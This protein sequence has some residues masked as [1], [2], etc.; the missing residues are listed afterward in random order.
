MDPNAMFHHL[1]Q[2][3]FLYYNTPFSL[4]DS[5]LQAE[6]TSLLDADHV[7]WRE[8]WLEPIPSY[9]SSDRTLEQTVHELGLSTEVAEFARKGLVPRA[10]PRLYSHQDEALV[11]YSKGRNVVLTAGTGS[12]KTEAMFLP[13]IAA[14]VSESATWNAGA[15]NLAS[16]WWSSAKDEWHPMRAGESGR[17]AAL[18][19]LVL[20]PMNALVEDQLVRLRR[21]LDS[22]DARSW[23]DAH[24]HGHRFFFGRYTGPTPV[25]G[26]PVKDAK[27]Y[28]TQELR[29][30]LRRAEATHAQAATMP[31]DAHYYVP[32][33][34]GAEMRSRWDML[35]H[36]PDIMITNYS[37]LNIMLMRQREEALFDQTR[38]WIEGGGTFHLVVDELHMYRGTQG[39]EVAYLIRKLLD[40]L[41]LS[42]RTDQLRILTSSASLEG[43]GSAFLEGFFSVP[44]TTFAAPVR[45]EVDT[46]EAEP[47][48]LTDFLDHFRRLDSEEESAA[49]ILQETKGGQRLLAAFLTS[50]ET[51]SGRGVGLQAQ[52][53]ASLRQTLFPGAP[54][55]QQIEAL[56]GLLRAVTGKRP[57]DSAGVVQPRIRQHLFFKNI[58]G[59]WACSDPSCVHSER[60][61]AVGKLFAR[62]RF[63]CDCGA[64]VLELL[65]CQNCGQVFLGGYST[66]LAGASDRWAM[67]PEQPDLGGV[68]EVIDSRK[69][70]DRYIVYWPSDENPKVTPN[71]WQRGNGRFSFQFK[72]S[73]LDPA[74]GELAWDGYEGS[75]WSFHV[76]QRTGEAEDLAKIPAAPTQCPSCGDDWERQFGRG[77]VRLGLLDSG[78]LKSPIR[79]MRTGF[80]KYAQVLTDAMLGAWDEERANIPRSA[81]EKAVIFSDSRQDAARLS[82]GIELNHYR[83]AVR[84]VI[85][86]A[87]Q[88]PGAAEL[89]G[90]DAAVKG[91]RGAEN[92]RGYGAIGRH[93]RESL[94]L[95]QEYATGMLDF[96][97]RESDKLVAQRL[98]ETIVKGARTF[99]A[100]V[101]HTED[102]LLARGI[103]PGGPTYWMQ[104]YFTG[105]KASRR[106]RPWTDLFLWEN[107]PPRPRPAADIGHPEAHE[108]MADIVNGVREQL[109]STMFSGMGRDLES[110]GLGVVSFDGCTELA[111][112]DDDSRES[113][114]VQAIQAT[115]RILGTRRWV[116]V[117][118]YRKPFV[119]PDGEPPAWLRDTWKRMA[120]A[121]G[122][123][124]D[125]IR[126]GVE[127]RMS[128]Q[129]MGY[130]LQASKL[131]LI[132]PSEEAWVCKKCRRRHLHRSA[133]VCSA[134]LTTLP[135]DPVSLSEVPVED[136]YART[137]TEGVVRRLHAEELT[138]QT[139]R[140]ESQARQARFQSIFLNDEIGLVD[141]I[142]ILSVTTTMEAGVDIGGLR[143]VVM[144]NMPPMRFNYQQRVGRAGRRSDP[145]AVA[146]T[147]CRERS[148]DE[149]Y[150]AD[151][152]RI[153][154]EPP[155]QP[156][157]DL[158]RREILRRV[159]NAEIL[160]LAFADVRGRFADFKPGTSTHGEFGAKRDWPEWA[161]HVRHWLASARADV[162][163]LLAA[164]TRSTFFASRTDWSQ[165]ISS[166][167]NDLWG[168]V[169]TVARSERATEWLSE[170][171]AET[172][173]LPMF[174]FPT[175]V[176]HLLYDYPWSSK[177]RP[178]GREWPPVTSVD[179]DL[180]IAVSQFAPGAETVKDGALH[181]AIGI[182]AW[183]PS[184]G[185][186]LQAVA[187]PLGIQTPFAYCRSCL[188]VELRSSSDGTS[189]PVCPACGETDRF[190]VTVLAEPEGFVTDFRP[191]D[192][193]GFDER[194][195][196]RTA[197]RVL[198]TSSH[199]AERLERGSFIAGT[200]TVFVI[201]DNGGALHTFAPD[202]PSGKGVA[203]RW[204]DLGLVNSDQKAKTLRLPKPEDLLLDHART[205][206]LGATLHTDVLRI[207]IEDLPQGVDLAIA[208][209]PAWGTWDFSVAKRA[210]WYSL[211]FLLIKAA[212]QYLQIETR[213]LVLGLRS[214]KEDGRVG[215]EL[216][217]ADELDNGAGYSTH[218]GKAEIVPAFVA[219]AEKLVAEDFEAERHSSSCDASC[220]D[221]I[222]EHGNQPYHP[223]LDWRLAV[224]MLELLL[225]A[226]PAD[227]IARER[228]RGGVEARQFAVTVGGEALK[229]ASGVWGLKML[230]RVALIA[231]PIERLDVGRS[232]QLATVARREARDHGTVLPMAVTSLDVARRPTWVHSYLASAA[233]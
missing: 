25:S 186:H 110:L 205:V 134:C 66:P 148:H 210:A 120:E 178:T 82:A 81:W 118:P 166:V 196:G 21:A 36:P 137:A 20:Y 124:Y 177:A 43:D 57:S 59:M 103:N 68:P 209:E 227:A 190:I 201:N 40:R 79:T 111:A 169:D 128:L 29:A 32:S 10:I 164:L 215:A 12:G 165:F 58:P 100:L 228:D 26:S 114:L 85:I 144:G 199:S 50:T 76:T 97:G 150:F 11:Q 13:L 184:G 147:L 102:E 197:P 53:M 171:L 130:L 115:V 160:R 101:Q 156:Y 179:R 158:Q 86:T 188:H 61:T 60:T 219:A 112:R 142:D 232:L 221:C 2:Q 211:G 217:I 51:A 44:A 73:Y 9:I 64:R 116:D 202:A 222:R 42:S 56:A 157:L 72:R 146:L 170:A 28:R 153:T 5:K 233:L 75:G 27:H 203:G 185:G 140:N 119:S 69:T 41:G 1:R 6:R 17:V 151:P 154:S 22:T 48:N 138:G 145:L 3:L 226:D 123:G 189:L 104:R 92:M 52:S 122:I 7:A 39:T 161:E 90:F 15:P 187:D 96:P 133:G 95:L 193:E 126:S 175:K 38:E 152:R 208:P 45:G 55:N 84:A 33:V 204:V 229:F 30:Y 46:S 174:G 155:P 143:S 70:A 168:E 195:T 173:V 207:R 127:A 167:T 172:G 129:E 213:E 62:P 113:V 180:S 131:L 31:G 135:V 4:A 98:R 23:L 54:E 220:Y 88:G 212:A 230:G 63:R 18:R 163:R 182:A 47:G 125:K 105:T 87:L 194:S 218:L 121:C 24:R 225:G 94:G 224:D 198:P 77:G 214:F 159:L 71:P 16:K 83:D 149:T 99:P 19:A 200:G 49:A 231:H 216:F 117:Y 136:Y 191:R 176:R 139:D 109:V 78:R 106:E 141:E 192:Y 91:D 35:T 74:S 37:M 132:P 183:E 65:Y 108:L 206:A 93:Y 89:A 8:P 80:S 181:T 162:E 223:I 67:L 107:T 34:D 14:M